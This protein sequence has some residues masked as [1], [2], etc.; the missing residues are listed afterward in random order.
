MYAWVVGVPVFLM[1]LVLVLDRLESS[2]FAPM[3]RP[4]VTAAGGAGVEPEAGTA[5]P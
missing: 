2:V 4:I 1:V 3:D 5:H